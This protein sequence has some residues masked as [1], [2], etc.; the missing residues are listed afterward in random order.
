MWAEEENIHKFAI[1]KTSGGRKETSEFD[2]SRSEAESTPWSTVC[3]PGDPISRGDLCSP[4][5]TSRSRNTCTTGSLLPSKAAVF[6]PD[7]TLTTGLE[8]NT[9]LLF[10]DAVT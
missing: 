8:R 3:V 2:V 6:A 1:S 10:S 4:A 5:N 9:F 7:W